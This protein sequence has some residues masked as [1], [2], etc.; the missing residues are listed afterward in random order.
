MKVRTEHEILTHIE[1]VQ[2]TDWMG[3]IRNDLIS[4]L[5]FE[6]AKQFLKDGV[7]DKD[8]MAASSDIDSLKARIKD[9]MD[10][11]WEK[12]NDNRGISAGRSIEHMQAWL[13]MM[14]ENNVAQEIENY[15]F[16]GKPQLRAICEKF[17]WDWHDWDDD[18][19]VNNESD[20]GVTADSIECIILP[21]ND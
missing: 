3:T 9:Y 14:G 20:P 4:Y 19:W 13:W 18:R 11:A 15:S 17:G 21:W 8:W 1:E 2:S 12:A 16:Y 7:T 6:S 10:F 5:P